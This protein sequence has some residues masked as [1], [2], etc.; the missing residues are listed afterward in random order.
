MLEPHQ[1]EL[2]ERI[3]SEF[4]KVIAE[5]ILF[6][7]KD[8]GLE[9]LGLAWCEPDVNP[10]KWSIEGVNAY[11]MMSVVARILG[12]R[13]YTRIYRPY[14]EQTSMPK[15]LKDYL[16]EISGTNRVGC[17]VEE[18]TRAVGEQGEIIGVVL[19]SYLLHIENP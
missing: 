8:M 9:G 12:E 11:E 5:R 17:S 7:R 13:R 18:I 10:S 19:M 2:L 3:R 14:A 6:A 15:F 1:D 16:G 4:K